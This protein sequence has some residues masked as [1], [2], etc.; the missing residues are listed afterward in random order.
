MQYLQITPNL[1]SRLLFGLGNFSSQCRLPTGALCMAANWMTY[2][3]H[4]I[5]RSIALVMHF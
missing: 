3:K 2:V 5:G 4:L 1:Y